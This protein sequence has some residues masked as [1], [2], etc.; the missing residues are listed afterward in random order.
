[1]L[2]NASIGILIVIIIIYI[3]SFQYYSGTYETIYNDD[4]IN[5]KILKTGDIICFKAYNNFN[6]IF[7]GNYYGHIG[8]VYVDPNNPDEPYLFEANGVEKMALKDHH[9]KA[10]IFLTPVKERIAKYKGRCF[11]KGLNKEIHPDVCKEFKQFI[12]YCLETMKYE[13]SIFKSSIKKWIGWERCNHNTNC[14]ELI[15]LSLIKLGLIPYEMYDKPTLHYL[16]WMCNIKKLENDYYYNDLIQI[17]DH[18][19]KD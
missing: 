19:F 7:I 6:S 10:G 9:N 16:K 13:K 15:F 1:M 8:I 14:G 18:P 11:Y 2:V 5:S 3:Y 17:I 4:L 12:D